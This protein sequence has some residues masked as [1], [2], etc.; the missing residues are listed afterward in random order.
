MASLLGEG[1]VTWVNLARKLINLPLI[2]LMSLNQVLLGLMSARQ[3]RA[4]LRLLQG[5]IRTTTLLSLPAAVGLIATSPALVSILLP[6][7][8]IDS[9]LPTLLAWF[10]VPL[11]FGA[12]NA[13]LARYAYADSDTRLPLK[14]EL[15]GSLV[16]ALLLALLPLLAGLSG[17]P[18]AALAGVITTGLLL[19]H[20]QDLLAALPWRQHWGLSLGVMGASAGGLFA[21]ENTWQQL[22]LGVLAGATVLLAL[23]VWLRPWRLGD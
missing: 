11:V 6:A 14:C 5:G 10:S 9:P 22:L 1:T 19:M 12:W 18:L 7:Q 16:N 23:A 8:G 2:A 21:L 15:A 13:L 4:R 20:R 3:G 17:I